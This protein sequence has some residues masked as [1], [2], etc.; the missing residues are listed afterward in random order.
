L[1]LA[2]TDHRLDGEDLPDLKTTSG[3]VSGVMRDVRHA[4]EESVRETHDQHPF[5]AGKRKRK[6][7]A[8]VDSV[9]AV[10][11]VRR[12]A[13]LRRNLLNPCSEVSVLEPRDALTDRFVETLSGGGDEVKVLGRDF[14]DGVCGRGEVSGEK[15]E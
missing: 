2:C 6:E 13:F 3:L 7:D 5:L 14:A 10:L 1:L 15:K 4:M 11:L 8:L 12:E 9:T